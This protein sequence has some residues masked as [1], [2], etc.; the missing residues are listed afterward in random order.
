MIMIL[1]MMMMADINVIAGHMHT[2]I[3]ARHNRRFL[4]TATFP[5]LD[6][7]CHLPLTYFL[8]VDCPAGV[9]AAE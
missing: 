4:S 9:T 6:T 5:Q 7:E 2:E 3:D 1:N 8:L